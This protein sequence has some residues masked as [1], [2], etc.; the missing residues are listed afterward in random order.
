M[1]TIEKHVDVEVP[2]VAAYNQWTQFESFPQFMRDVRAVNQLDDRTLH[3]SA[4]LGG[5][6]RDME[7]RGRE[8]GAWRGE[9]STAEE[10]AESRR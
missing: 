9:I 2:A 5:V 10:R 4:D 8:T 3:W 7:R 6:R 1:T